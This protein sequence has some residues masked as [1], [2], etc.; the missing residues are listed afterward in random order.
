MGLPGNNAL[1]ERILENSL[2]KKAQQKSENI[3]G[4]EKIN[5]SLLQTVQEAEE[6]FKVDKITPTQQHNS[7]YFRFMCGEKKAYLDYK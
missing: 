3:K 4:I 6:L 5:L 1:I 7:E 2:D